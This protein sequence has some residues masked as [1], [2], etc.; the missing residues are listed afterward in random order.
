VNDEK[1]VILPL[2][3]KIVDGVLALQGYTLS[4]GQ[5]Q[6]LSKFFSLT[7]SE[8]VHYLALNNCGIH[9]EQMSALLRG[10]QKADGF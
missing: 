7:T 4:M 6:A 8:K 5:C 10:L 3:T 9:D 1:E 2:P